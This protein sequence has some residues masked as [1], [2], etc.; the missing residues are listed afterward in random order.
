MKKMKKIEFYDQ[1]ERC[2]IGMRES[3]NNIE[4]LF[5]RYDITWE[6]HPY[7]KDQ[8][9]NLWDCSRG[10]RELYEIELAKTDAK[11]PWF[12]QS[13]P[14]LA[15]ADRTGKICHYDAPTIP[16]KYHRLCKDTVKVQNKNGCVEKKIR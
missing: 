14:P 15:S 1:V 7:L 5:D 3:F 13:W 6:S 12:C 16:A 9:Y 10:V 11:V 4:E 8:V 2:K